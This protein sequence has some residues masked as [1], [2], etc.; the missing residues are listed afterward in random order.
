[1]TDEEQ[2]I[3][4]IND[5]EI[6][7]HRPDG[8]MDSLS[9]KNL[10][11]VEIVVTEDTPLPVTFIAL[12]GPNSTVVIP[13]GATNADDLGE[14]LFTLEGFDADTFVESMSAQTADTFLCWTLQE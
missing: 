5:D 10:Q 4:E 1:M 13:E 3:L 12:H 2:Y 14:R 7:C 9:W 11:R 6:R 8:T